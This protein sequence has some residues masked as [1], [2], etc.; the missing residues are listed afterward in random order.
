MILSM[1]TNK[2]ITR[3]KREKYSMDG[4]TIYE[5]YG[6]QTMLSCYISEDFGESIVNGF[7]GYSERTGRLSLVDLSRL[8]LVSIEAEMTTSI[9]EKI[10][11][12]KFENLVICTDSLYETVILAIMLFREKKLN[13]FISMNDTALH[14][15]FTRC[16]DEV[17][18]DNDKCQ[19]LCRYLSAFK[20][21]CTVLIVADDITKEVLSLLYTDEINCIVIIPTTAKTRALGIP[22]MMIKG[23][24]AIVEEENNDKF[25]RTFLEIVDVLNIQVNDFI[26]AYLLNSINS[27]DKLQ[28]I[29]AIC[30][31]VRRL[32]L[33]SIEEK[34]GTSILKNAA[35]WSDNCFTGCIAQ[36]G[37]AYVNSLNDCL[38]IIRYLVSIGLRYSKSYIY[39]IS[40]MATD[41][42]DSYKLGMIFRTMM[43]AGYSAADEDIRAFIANFILR[44]QNNDHLTPIDDSHSPSYYQRLDNVRC[45]QLQV[46]LPYI[47]ENVFSMRDAD[48]KTLLITAAERLEELPRLF[49][50]IL[51]HT[52]DV[53]IIDENGC[54]ALHYVSDLEKWDALVAAGADI[55]IKD[56]DGRLPSISFDNEDMQKLLAK[57]V[58]SDS[59]RAYAERMLFLLL[60]DCYTAEI[61][62]EKKNLIM[63]L[64]EIIRPTA[65]RTWDG[66]TPFMDIIVQ[67][68]Y[69][70]DIY[71]KMLGIGIDI[72]AQ[73]TSGNN[74]LRIAILS[75]ECTAAK[76]RYLIE[77]GADE[78]PHKYMGSVATIAA[79]LFHIRSIEWEA[80]WELSDKSLFSYHDSEAESPIMIALRYQNIEAIRFLFSHDAVPNDELALIEDRINKIKT[81]STRIECMQLFSSYMKSFDKEVNNGNKE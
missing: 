77:H 12:R 21:E 80:L 68:G 13:Y 58:F 1:K 20:K 53:N 2:L 59:D 67:E 38:D 71:D 57:E 54:T 47:P 61:I 51:Q 52:P 11:K 34:Y 31:R 76:I 28:T 14:Q 62:Y 50:I 17:I 78:A 4:E 8:A 23:I 43:E 6:N 46:M 55:D 7:V 25:K 60:D 32:N 72:N 10:L 44:A 18:T 40:S 30:R 36:G 9:A 65:K 15:E 64:L 56:K 41:L 16:F 27:T 75:P 29:Q 49:K 24:S 79:G 45:E 74:A 69:F 42:Y 66:Y 39:D 70:P 48:G 63:S 73:D 33:S 37:A 19:I 22:Q 5:A 3:F 81:E 26:Y 35:Y